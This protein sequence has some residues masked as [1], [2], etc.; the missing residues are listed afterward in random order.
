MVY[1]KP[2]FAIM[3]GRAGGIAEPKSLESKKLGAPPAG[4]SVG[5]WALFAKLNDIDRP[6]S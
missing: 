3:G 1:N 2:P 6:R 5:E 4:S